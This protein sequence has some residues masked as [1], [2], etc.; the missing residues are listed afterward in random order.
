M[1]IFLR[2]I[3]LKDR[4]AQREGETDNQLWIH[5]PVLRQP[6]LNQAE[7]NS[8]EL[9]LCL[10]HGE[11]RFKQ[12]GHLFLISQSFSKELGWNWNSG[13]A[14]AAGGSLTDHITTQAL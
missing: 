2:F 12:L 1:N 13:D 11:Q 8:Q 10:P 7:A 4:V 6:G 3:Y 5:F 14:A 9:P